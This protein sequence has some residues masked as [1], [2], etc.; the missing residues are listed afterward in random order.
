LS[1]PSEKT[2]FAF[3]NYTEKKGPRIFKKR[4]IQLLLFIPVVKEGDQMDESQMRK[5]NFLNFK[6]VGEG[7]IRNGY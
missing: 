5:I 1:W 7:K 6:S 3:C 4:H 2:K